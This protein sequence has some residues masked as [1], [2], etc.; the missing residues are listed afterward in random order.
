[1]QGKKPGQQMPKP[2]AQVAQA[3]NQGKNPGSQSKPNAAVN[4]AGRD[5]QPGVLSQKPQTDL[6]KEIQD[7]QAEWGAISPRLRDAVIEGAHD[8]PLE[9]Y[10]QL[11]DDYWKSL[12]TK[13]KER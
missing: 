13:A 8:Q 1:N 4:P 3:N 7:S 9:E 11:I 12:S 2:G 10:R 5:S 6:S